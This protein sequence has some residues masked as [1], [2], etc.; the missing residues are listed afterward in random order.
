MFYLAAILASYAELGVDGFLTWGGIFFVFSQSEAGNW[1]RH[2][3]Q[4]EVGLI[5]EC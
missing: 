5:S 3:S 4:L 1:T 2:M